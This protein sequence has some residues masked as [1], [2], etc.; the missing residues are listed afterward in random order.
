MPEKR[1]CTNCGNTLKNT[2]NFCMECGLK[3][4]SNLESNVI[5]PNNQQ[6]ESDQ[7][8]FGH[9]PDIT[10][11]HFEQPNIQNN[12][13]QNYVAFASI[14]ISIIGFVIFLGDAGFLIWISLGVCA[15]GI[16]VGIIGI[17]LPEYKNIIAPAIVG[18][19]LNVVVIAALLSIYFDIF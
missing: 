15:I 2:D 17:V 5:S 16:I 19:I 11:T 4:D 14:V 10:I 13:K 18:I 3:M 8:I 9:N 1:F 7:L 6:P 12:K